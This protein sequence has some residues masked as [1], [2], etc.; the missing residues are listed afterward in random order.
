MI[1]E[2]PIKKSC[3]GGERAGREERYGGGSGGEGGGGGGNEKSLLLIG[4]G[5]PRYANPIGKGRKRVE[6]E[7]DEQRTRVEAPGER[8]EEEAPPPR[9][10]GQT[11]IHLFSNAS[12]AAHSRRGLFQSR[13]LGPSN[14]R[15]GGTHQPTAKNCEQQ[16]QEEEE[17]LFIAQRND[18]GGGGGEEAGG[19]R[20]VDGRRTEN[21]EEEKRTRSSHG[22]SD[23]FSAHSSRHPSAVLHSSIGKCPFCQPV[24]QRNSCVDRAQR[25]AFRSPTFPFSPIWWS[26]R[27]SV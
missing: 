24:K 23:T 2:R 8:A 18:A 21:D 5:C 17:K 9:P 15:E 26:G 25:M 10:T 7:E 4:H 13:I 19:V 27:P 16:H 14:G 22:S 12:A 6:K 11:K 20:P 3:E 1:R